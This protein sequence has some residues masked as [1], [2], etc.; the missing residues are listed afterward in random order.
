M[1][2]HSRI[3]LGSAMTGMA[4][5]AAACNASSSGNGSTST[6]SPATTTSPASGGGAVAIV[7]TVSNAKLGTILDDAK[8][9][10]LYR[11][12]NDG[13]DKSNCTGSCATLWPPL[14]VPA[15]T[16]GTA[17]AGQMSGF[18]TIKRSNG[19][20]QVTYH[21]MPLYTYAGDTSAG[22]TNGQGVGGTWFV[23]TTGSSS[24]STTSTTTAHSSY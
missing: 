3:A 19:T 10:T 1:A 8:G 14:T 24:G 4:L 2:R 21:G 18:G 23:V 9:F 7:K 17:I 11:F 16:A 12:T 22:Q 5:L 20:L 13:M 15:G 6:S